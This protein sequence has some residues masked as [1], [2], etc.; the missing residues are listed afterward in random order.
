MGLLERR[1][2]V[3]GESVIEKLTEGTVFADVDRTC[4]G[5]I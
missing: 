1:S 3:V 4:Q 5:M 2:E